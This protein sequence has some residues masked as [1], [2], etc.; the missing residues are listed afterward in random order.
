MASVGLIIFA[1]IS[2]LDTPHYLCF[3]AV[4]LGLL[5]VFVL[6]FIC[7]AHIFNAVLQSFYMFLL[8]QFQQYKKERDKKNS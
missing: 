1:S 7:V 3:L 5:R 2:L 8:N 6:I 4:I